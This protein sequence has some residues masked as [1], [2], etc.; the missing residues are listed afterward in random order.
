MNCFS[1]VF[2]YNKLIEK[3]IFYNIKIKLYNNNDSKKK[4]EFTIL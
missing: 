3:L 2:Q 1:N 4:L